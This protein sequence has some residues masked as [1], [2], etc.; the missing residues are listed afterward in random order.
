M[1]VCVLLATYNGEKYLKEQLF[2]LTNQTGVK[3]SLL[4]SDDNSTDQ[5]LNILDKFSKIKFD[6]FRI[7]SVLHNN[8]HVS[9]NFNDIRHSKLASMASDNFCNLIRNA[10]ESDDYYAF[11]DQD[12][13]WHTDKLQR[14][15]SILKKNNKPML[16][17]SSSNLVNSKGEFTM[18]SPTRK[19]TPSFENALVQSLAAGNTMVMNKAAFLLLKRSIKKL[20]IPAHDWWTYILISA[21]GGEVYYDSKALIDYRIHDGNITGTNYNFIQFFTRLIIAIRGNYKVWN[22]LNC[23]A[24]NEN[25]D[26]LN[27]NSKKILNLFMKARQS[28]FFYRNYYLFKSGVFREQRYQKILFH[29]GMLFNKI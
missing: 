28:S 20:T 29:I 18:K 7:I 6:N 5:T 13:I 27:E 23:E 12:D 11:S 15:V 19:V 1:N 25:I 8:E 17:C 10:S 2:S 24:L 22:D 4:V 9:N 3:V 14:A 26:I 21:A 16:Y